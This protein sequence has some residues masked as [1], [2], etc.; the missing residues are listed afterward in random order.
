MTLADRGFPDI[1]DRAGRM[2]GRAQPLGLLEREKDILAQDFHA[3]AGRKRAVQNLC[4]E[5]IFG[6]AVSAGTDIDHI[7]GHV[8]VYARPHGHQNHF[9]R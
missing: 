3:G 6:R 1:P 2:M 9:A 8:W 5:E 4:L 7:D